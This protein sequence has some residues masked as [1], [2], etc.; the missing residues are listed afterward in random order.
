MYKVLLRQ[1]ILNRLHVKMYIKN[2]MNNN[3]FY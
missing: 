1:N 3:Y 2:L